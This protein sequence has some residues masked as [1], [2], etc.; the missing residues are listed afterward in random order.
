[1]SSTSMQQKPLSQRSRLLPRSRRTAPPPAPSKWAASFPQRQAV[2]GFGTEVSGSQLSGS[3]EFLQPR[4][5]NGDQELQQLQD[6]AATVQQQE[7]QQQ[8]WSSNSAASTSSPDGGSRSASGKVLPT[9]LII[10]L[11]RRGEGWGEEFIP[12]L[13]VEQRPIESRARLQMA[14]RA[15]PWEVGAGLASICASP[16]CHQRCITLHHLPPPASWSS[17]PLPL[18]LAL[19]CAASSPPAPSTSGCSRTGVRPP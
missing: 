12:F 18:P 13:T 4:T 10:R 11:E 9:E 2:A 8:R 14:E 17:A 7:Q 16:L 3:G 1:M 19:S 5:E 6:E 15:E